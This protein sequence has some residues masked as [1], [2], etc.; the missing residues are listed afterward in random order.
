M[1][2]EIVRS[3]ANTN[4]GA[5]TRWADFFHGMLLLIGVASI[6]AVLNHIPLAALAAMLCFTGYNLASP[7]EFAH[8]WHVG[9]EQLVIFVSHFGRGARH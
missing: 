5:K 3:S 4:N 9:K 6:P 8:M 1:I 7:K 2:S